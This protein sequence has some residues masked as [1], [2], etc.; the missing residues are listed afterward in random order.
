LIYATCLRKKDSIR[1]W[2][3]D[4]DCGMP[5]DSQEGASTKQ[6]GYQPQN[7]QDGC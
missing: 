4:M 3:H 5:S 1:S 7:V 2:T 6:L